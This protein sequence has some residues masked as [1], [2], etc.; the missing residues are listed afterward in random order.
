MTKINA[1]AVQK[2]FPSPITFMNSSILRNDQ[3]CVGGAFC[4]FVNN[5]EGKEVMPIQFLTALTFPAHQFLAAYLSHVNPNL[6][7]GEALVFAT[8]ITLSN[9]YTNFDDAWAHLD[10]ALNFGEVT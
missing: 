3:Y 10:E 9:D 4:L 7:E 2:R 8:A 5:L 6:K 1:A